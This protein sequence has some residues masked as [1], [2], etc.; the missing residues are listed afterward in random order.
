[1][2]A[3]IRLGKEDGVAAWVRGKHLLVLAK[4]RV[5]IIYK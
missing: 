4:K 1:M 3:C 2:T 5:L